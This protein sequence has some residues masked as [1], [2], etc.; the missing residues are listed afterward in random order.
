[1]HIADFVSGSFAGAC[2]VAVGY[3]LDTVKVRIQTQKQFTGLWQ[4]TVATFSKEGVHG[5]FKGMSFPITTIS[6][7]SSVVFGTYRNCLQ[8]LSQARGDGCGP[9]TKLEVFLSGL[10]AGIAQISVM[11]PGDIVK[12]RLQCQTESKRGG[13]N[14]PKP[15]YHGPVHCV[16]SIIKEEGIMGLY[17][18]ALPLMLRDGPSYATYFLTYAY[19]CEWLTENGKNRP[20]WSGVM[21]AG[22]IAG[23]AAWTIGTPM[24][25]IKARLQMDGALGMKRYNGFYHCITETVRTEGVGV[26]FR[27]LGINCLRAFPVNMVVFVTYEVLTGFLRGGPDGASFRV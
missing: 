16:L 12:V 13:T 19:I 25:V 27:S 6:M 18:G 11:S 22:G 7:T 2:G 10:V 1:M 3:P 26:F 9:N 8:C 17:R 5:F 4:C 20:D 15:R 24:D 23:M 14:I 21:L